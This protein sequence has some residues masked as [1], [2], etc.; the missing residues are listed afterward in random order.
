MNKTIIIRKHPHISRFA[1]QMFNVMSLVSQI[2]TSASDSGSELSSS[3]ELSSSPELLLASGPARPLALAHRSAALAASL[4][5]GSDSSS[6]SESSSLLASASGWP[7]SSPVGV[8]FASSSSDVRN[9]PLVSVFLP[10]LSPIGSDL[11]KGRQ[12]TLTCMHNICRGTGCALHDQVGDTYLKTQ[13]L[14]YVQEVTFSV[15]SPHACDGPAPSAAFVLAS[16]QTWP[17]AAALMPSPWLPDRASHCL[18]LPVL[19]LL[20]WQTH[21]AACRLELHLVGCYLVEIAVS[22]APPLQMQCVIFSKN[23]VNNNA[24]APAGDNP[25]AHRKHLHRLGSCLAFFP[26]PPATT[27]GSD[28][29]SSSIVNAMQRI[30]KAREADL[31]VLQPV[32]LPQVFLLYLL[33]KFSASLVHCRLDLEGRVLE[34]PCHSEQDTRAML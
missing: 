22:L 30:Y 24:H 1:S 3:A 15:D 4:S 17:C 23:C 6:G 26:N 33:A 28:A 25:K 18:L 20:F 8:G 2:R 32:V 10:M 9:L 29:T 13:I 21:L 12:H 5:A 31:L 34:H 11:E 14:W 27:Q 7:P 19:S 16:L